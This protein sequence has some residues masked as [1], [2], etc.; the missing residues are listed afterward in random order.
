MSLRRRLL[1][2]ILALLAVAIGVT[3]AVTYHSLGTF[4]AGRLDAQL[5]VAE[6]QVFD[7]IWLAY[8]RAVAADQ[9]RARRDPASW[10]AAEVAGVPGPNCPALTATKLT[11]TSQ[12]PPTRP[13]PGL[14]RPDPFAGV[15]PEVY[16]EVLGPGRRVL[17]V[18]PSGGC[19][20]A[21]ALP[22]T[23][24]IQRVP[25]RPPLGAR[26]SAFLPNQQAFTVPAVGGAVA[27]RAEAV[28]L[29][30]GVLVSAV[31]LSADRATLARVLRIE[32]LVSLGV[33]LVAVVVA[34][35]VTR[36]AL[37]PLEEM[38]ST[39]QAIA[40][41]ELSR[42]VR[43]GDER[44]EVGR[45]GQALNTMLGQ[46]EAAFAARSHSEGRLRR[47]VADASHE[48]RTPLTTI[49]G[50]AELLRKG[51]YAS[52]E[53]QREVAARIEREAAR[54]G[55]LVDDLL[56]LA[57]LDQG[58]ALSHQRLDLAVLAREAAQAARVGAQDHP[59]TVDCPA[60]VPVVGDPLRLR[61]VIDNLLQNALRHT[62][63]GTPVVVG[64]HAEGEEAVLVV[65]DEGPGLAPGEEILIFER[66]YRSPAARA[67]AGAGLGLAI[68]A[69][70]VA[71]HGGRVDV[72]SRPGR[73]CRFTVR[74]PLAPP[75][76]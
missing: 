33:L 63:P 34:L 49:R 9:L 73:G 20:P 10:L 15:S 13:R 7:R 53:A 66:F 32:V 25:A 21:P 64:V 74:L 12:P 56:L 26:G 72:D 59:L 19:D 1:L 27:Y 24:P 40:A 57:Q 52:A 75:S 29:P 48:L 18:R 61:Q 45:L 22:T 14:H 8:R 50:Y 68:V 16:L 35:V 11:A 31:A 43:P 67:T 71:A 39:A 76:P 37:A 62:P 42:R 23:M 58:R 5:D 4:L 54:M 2:G 3:D 51:A 36:V 6:Q 44:T 70:L 46:I 41:G 28:E 55:L 60:S 47:F 17:A 38:A 69:A 65:A 30:G